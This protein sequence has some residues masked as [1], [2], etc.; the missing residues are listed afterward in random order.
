M[1]AFVRAYRS[2][3]L[4]IGAMSAVINVLTLTG[5]IYMLEVY[6]RVLPSRSVP[7]LV[8]ISAIAAALFLMQGVLEF[9]RSRVLSRIGAA[10]DESFG[11]RVYES[12]IRMPLLAR[13]GGDGMQPLRD[14]DTVRSFMASAGPTALFDLPW[15]PLYLAIAFLFHPYI[16]LAAVV[17]SLI[18]VALTI[19]AETRTREP[20]RAASQALAQRNA[21]TESTRRNAEAIRAMGMGRRL[22]TRWS[23]TH[24]KHLDESQRSSDIGG[25]LGTMSRTLRLMLQ[26]MILGLGA[27]LA[28]HQEVSSGSIIA[29]S[30]LMSRAMQPV[31][32]AIANWRPFIGARQSWTR[33]MALLSQMPAEPEPMALPAPMGQITAETLVI[34]PPGERR[35]VVQDVS[36]SLARG[37]GL[38][39]IG[40]SASG[41]SSLVRGLTGVWP[42]VRG[43]IRLDGASLD[44]WSSEELGR[45]VGYLPQDIELF[46]GTIAENISRFEPDARPQDIIAAATHAGVHDLVLRLPQ[47]YETR[48]GEGGLA[49]SAGQRQRIGLA[50]ALYGDPF[51]VVLDEPNSNLDSAGEEALTEAIVGVRNRGG[52]VVVVAHRP[53]ALAGVDLILVMNEGRMQGFGPKD[54]VFEKFVRRAVAPT[55]LKAVGAEGGA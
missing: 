12:I 21:F 34:A 6:D 23:D 25:G 46:D 33:L 10:L 3:F 17:G 52:I 13:T 44:Q 36:F 4:G 48:V 2:A 5:T 1:R 37:Q 31:E 54:E 43:T 55:R 20:S 42:L 22:A 14:L 26:S 49:L 9:L 16:G 47:G 41:K 30:V 35:I 32:L 50:R 29:C 24:L 51:L 38:G 15:M 45:H 18:L 28:I 39:I 27:Y 53:S 7:T 19:A 40:P 11:T 8:G